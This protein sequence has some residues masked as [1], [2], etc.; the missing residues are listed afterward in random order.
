M[1][2]CLFTYFGKVRCSQSRRPS[3][4]M[5]PPVTR[6]FLRIFHAANERSAL[7]NTSTNH[8]EGNSEQS[9]S[10]HFQN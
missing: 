8:G 3:K 1:E 4:I 7:E 6:L 9:L 2:A 10:K 5:K